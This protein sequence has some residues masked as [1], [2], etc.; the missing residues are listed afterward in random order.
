MHAFCRHPLGA[1]KPLLE[2]K[3]FS[4]NQLSKHHCMYYAF[5]RHVLSPCFFPCSV[6]VENSAAH[7][8]V[9]EVL[10]T[11]GP[12]V[13]SVQP[14]LQPQAPPPVPP[15]PSSASSSSS[16]GGITAPF[17]PSPQP[18]SMSNQYITFAPEDAIY[19]AHEV[20]GGGLGRGPPPPPIV[21]PSAAELGP[22]EEQEWYWGNISRCVYSVSGLGGGCHSHPWGWYWGQ[23]RCEMRHKLLIQRALFFF[24]IV[25]MQKKVC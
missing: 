9:V 12:W 11:K 8:R 21:T 14:P 3:T 23:R 17:R 18:R 2:A 10:L 19:E 16:L 15:R 13:S 25:S 24:C 1:G 4:L 5:C 7:C 6:L 20:D 22:V